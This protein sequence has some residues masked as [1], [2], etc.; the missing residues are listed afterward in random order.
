LSK[1]KHGYSE[2]DHTGTLPIDVRSVQIQYLR[3]LPW[4]NTRWIDTMQATIFAW[5]I[6]KSW[7]DDRYLMENA[8]ALNLPNNT[9]MQFQSVQ[10]YLHVSILSKIT[11]HCRTHILLM[12]IQQSQPTLNNLYQSRNGSSLSWPR[13]PAPGPKA[14]NTWKE[15]L[16]V[17]YLQ[18]NSYQLSQPLGPWTKDYATDY[19]LGR[20]MCLWSYTLFHN[21]HRKWVAFT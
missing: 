18:H 5:Q 10:L 4:S 20:Q 8:L 17:L 21:H 3:L 7:I 1:Y 16:N 6:P 2:Q 12:A 11:N 14:W 15:V 9:A 19:Q 13:Q